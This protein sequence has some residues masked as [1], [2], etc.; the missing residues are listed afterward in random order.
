MSG[1][2]SLFIARDNNTNFAT[3]Q[4]ITNDANAMSMVD[5]NMTHYFFIWYQGATGAASSLTVTLSLEGGFEEDC[6]GAAE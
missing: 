4:N 2:S 6:I 3:L 5:Y 1:I